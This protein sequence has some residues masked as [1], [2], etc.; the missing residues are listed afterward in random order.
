[1]KKNKFFSI[2]SFL[3][4]LITTLKYSNSELSSSNLSSPSNEVSISLSFN[5]GYV[6][7][8]IVCLTSMLE[9]KKPSSIYNYYLLIP[10]D[11]TTENQNIIRSLIKKYANTTITFFKMGDS[12]LGANTD[13]RI[14]LASYYRLCL[15]RLLPKVD[16][17]IYLDGDTLIFEDLTE[18]IN[19]NMKDKYVL[20]FPDI[21]IDALLM[22]GIYKFK[23]ICVGVILIDL[24]SLRKYK[25]DEKF[26]QFIKDYKY[27]LIQHDQTTIN[28]V[29]NDKISKL[30]PKYG[31]WA[32]ESIESALVHNR[33]LH[34]NFRYP[35]NELI[36]AQMHPAIV[37]FAGIEKPWEKRFHG[38]YKRIWWKYA[39]LTDYYQ[40]IKDKYNKN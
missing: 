30:P 6:Y 28:V 4:I 21:Y 34:S 15:P 29:L 24:E 35:E 13:Y 16:R 40:Q 11:L 25:Y 5:N 2:F 3:L 9:N 18:M 1:M 19:L 26:D 31:I 36:E 37:H 27:K 38:K 7:T 39:A 17:I 8:T 14:P 22:F 33:E 32:F 20:G 10:D 23:Y 12:F